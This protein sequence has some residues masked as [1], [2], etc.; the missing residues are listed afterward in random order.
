VAE[1]T[2]DF[3]PVTAIKPAVGRLF[4]DADQD[5]IVLSHSLF[6]RRFAADP[7]VIGKTVIVDSHPTTVVGVLPQGF[8]FL[9][10]TPSRADIDPTEI[11]AY[12]PANNLTPATQVRGRNNAIVNVVARFKPGVSLQQA[13]SEMEAIHAPNNI[14]TKLST[15]SWSFG[16]FPCRK[17][18]WRIAKKLMRPFGG[19]T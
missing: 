14:K 18:W 8:R 2:G 12:V 9:F 7:G 17:S 13:R 10:P 4:T 5:V 1:V 6:Q 15:A 3:W 11:E 19:S 16:W